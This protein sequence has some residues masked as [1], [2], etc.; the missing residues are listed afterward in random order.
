MT[1]LKIALA[2]TVTAI[3]GIGVSFSAAQ[4]S[5]AGSVQVSARAL[6]LAPVS[7]SAQNSKIE[8]DQKCEVVINRSQPAGVYDLTR[9]VS[10]G[11]DCICYVYTGP[12]SQ[13]VAIEN[14]IS[15]LMRSRTCANASVMNVPGG[16]GTGAAI[17]NGNTGVLLA[18][19]ASVAVNVGILTSGN[20]EGGILENPKVA[21][22]VGILTSGNGT[23]P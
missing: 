16:S 14:K 8:N 9:Q 5:G 13:S 2:I 4:V 3:T 11:G 6:G 21:V 18:I 23:S 10:D 17:A 22:G 7:A 12:S 1:N 20:G 15:A 19:A